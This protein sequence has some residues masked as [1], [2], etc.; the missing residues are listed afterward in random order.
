MHAVA[1]ALLPLKNSIQ[2]GF[3]LP[4]A[5]VGPIAWPFLLYIGEKIHDITLAKLRPMHLLRVI[6]P[7]I[8]REVAMSSEGA[9]P[10]QMWISWP[11]L[12]YIGERI[13]DMTLATL[14]PTHVMGALIL[15]PGVLTLEISKPPGFTYRRVF[16]RDPGVVGSSF[17][18]D[19]T[20]S[21][22]QPPHVMGEHILGSG[23]LIGAL[24][25]GNPDS[26]CPHQCDKVS[27]CDWDLAEGYALTRVAH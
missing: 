1:W 18:P 3:P 26:R 19:M 2:R 20:P 14:W 11:F 21:T 27:A 8:L 16:L 22:L 13:Y 24:W 6:S 12:L 10:L 25:V 7:R 17:I 23:V 15:D 9:L 5:D 4:P